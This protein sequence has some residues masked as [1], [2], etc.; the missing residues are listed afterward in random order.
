LYTKNRK[1]VLTTEFHNGLPCIIKGP[2]SASKAFV[3]YNTSFEQWHNALGHPSQIVPAAYQDGYV[4]PPAPLQFECIPCI[5]AKSTHKVPHTQERRS[6]HPF[7][8]IHSDLSGISPVPS[9]GNTRYYMT[10]IDDFT[11]MS[12]VYF[13]KS[14]DEAATAIKYFVNMVECQFSATILCFKADNGGEY[15]NNRTQTFWSN[16]GI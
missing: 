9:N 4:I 12:W 7:E 3:T 5:Q 2:K 1:L 16:K 14:E 6:S 13:L 15:I 8:I 10:F 11:R